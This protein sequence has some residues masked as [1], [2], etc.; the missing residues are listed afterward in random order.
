VRFPALLPPAILAGALLLAAPRAPAGDPPAAPDDGAVTVIGT[1]VLRRARVVVRG[2]LEKVASLDLGVEMALV[3]VKET[4]WGDPPG[5]D[6]IRI[7]S[8]EA[9]YFA[10]VSPDAVFFLE[11]L[12]GGERFTCRAVVDGAGEEGTARLAA[13]RRSLG[14]ERR[15][16]GERAAAL[17]AA[18]F[19]SLGA[20][21]RWTRQN[22]GREIAHLAEAVPGCFSDADLRDLRRAALRER[23]GV[24][25][26]LLVEAVEALSKAAEGGRLSPPDPGAVTLR[27]AP[28]LRRL[29][30]DPDP[31]VRRR[32]AEAAGREGEA[33]EAALGEA[34]EKDADASV[35]TAAAEALASAGS[36]ERSAPA[37]LRR[38]KEDG[39][40][41]V[42]NA[43]VEALG[44]LGASGAVDA[45]AALGRKDPVVA[46]SA[47]FA[48]ARIRTPE[49]VDA[50]KGI[51]AGAADSGEAGAAEARDLVDFLLSEAFLKQEE[52]LRKV[53]SSAEK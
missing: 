1:G 27:G 4:L 16:R 53:R 11:P 3:R 34:L 52:S 46:R 36:A 49:A 25:R 30:E 38:A 19:E 26:P 31:A 28:L 44:I 8:N 24:L 35:R 13:V 41:E 6:R 33:G 29:R 10:R 9:G 50:L 5:R 14:I 43:A 39:A 23:D 15:P 47:L 51:R 22:A 20:A 2:V 18:C 7:L 17:R 32:S 40:P 42:R 48:L 12:E 21:D 37:L 45:L